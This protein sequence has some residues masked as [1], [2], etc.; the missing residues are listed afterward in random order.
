MYDSPK[1]RDGGGG[2]YLEFFSNGT[3]TSCFA[4]PLAL[5]GVAQML[6]DSLGLLENEIK[7]RLAFIWQMRSLSGC[8]NSSSS[9]GDCDLHIGKGEGRG[10]RTALKSSAQSGVIKG[11]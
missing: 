10:G 7:S 1:R 11:I 4:E 3:Q 5:Q 9:G 8:S 6:H 2:T